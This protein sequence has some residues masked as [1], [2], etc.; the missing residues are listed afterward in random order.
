VPATQ[1][2]GA[3]GQGIAPAGWFADPG[4]RHELRYWDGQR[5]TEH[6]SDRGIP[7]VDTVPV[8]E[9]PRSRPPDAAVGDGGPPAMVREA[10][11]IVPLKRLALSPQC[12]FS[13]SE[14][15]NDLS[16]AQQIAKLRLVID[17]AEKVWG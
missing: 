8:A 6:V 15:G 4:R 13:S 11:R 7:G 16:V 9:G 1:P 2:V 10:A 3:R 17:T 12:G 14:H 5:W